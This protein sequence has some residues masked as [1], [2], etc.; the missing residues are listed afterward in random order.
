M[1]PRFTGADEF[2][3]VSQLLPDGSDDTPSRAEVGRLGSRAGIA[4]PG[5]GVILGK[6][7]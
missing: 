2:T 6:H 1:V 5:T 4:L 7:R 3:D